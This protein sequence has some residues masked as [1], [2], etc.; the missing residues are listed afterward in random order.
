MSF[1]Y[2]F[3]PTWVFTIIVYTLLAKQYGAKKS[4]PEA[5]AKEEQFNKLVEAYHEELATKEPILN[6][7]HSVFSKILKAIAIASLG[8]NLNIGRDRIIR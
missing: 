5:E 8:H 1:F 3:I 7:D 6:K 4:Y 2:L